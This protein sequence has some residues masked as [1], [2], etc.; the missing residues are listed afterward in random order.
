MGN[1][2]FAFRA[3]QDGGTVT[4]VKAGMEPVNATQEERQFTH[5]AETRLADPDHARTG[6]Y[7]ARLNAR[8]GRRQGPSIRLK[9]AAGDS[10]RADVY[11]RYDRES[12]AATLLQKGALVVGGTTI[13]VPGQAGSDQTQPLATRRHWLPF[14]GASL[15][16]VPQLLKVK[17]AELPTA[18]L[19][20]ELFNKDSQL[21]A[22]RTQA[23]R[24]TTSDEWQHLQAG[25]KADSAGFAH[26]SL[27][28]ESGTAA[29]FDDLALGIVA[30]TPYQ[31]NH[32]DPFGLNLV[33]IEQADVPNS[34]FQYNGKE[35][36]EDFN[37][38]WTDYGARM[39]DAQVGRW[40]SV[41]PL[42]DR[43]RRHSPYNYA[44]DNPIRFVDPD[45]MSP[46]PGITF[47]FAQGEAGAGMG[48]ALNYSRQE[49]IAYDKV[50]KTHFSM[51]S[52]SYLTNQN[53]Q[54]GSNNPQLVIGASAGLAVG[55]TQNWTHN[56]FG[57]YIEDASTHQWS[58]PTGAPSMKAEL[59]VGV[60]VS[61]DDFSLSFGPQIGAKA[62]RLSTV[63]EQSISLT[64][65]QAS[66]VSNATDIITESWDVSNPRAVLGRD[67][68]PTGFRATV[69]TLDTKGRKIDTGI[70]IFSTIAQ[71]K[72]GLTV[73]SNI[74]QSAEYM[75]ED[76]K[77]RK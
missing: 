28:N 6:D 26:V 44:F 56:T 63:V 46:W 29:Y 10:L 27:V 61:P 71:D 4:Q 37:L 50:G 58:S 70:S 17:Q 42:A 7:V 45:G 16:I 77:S 74:W 14:V 23:L 5:V 72:N 19:R 15:A 55:V 62:S 41:D 11:A 38:N 66:R 31:E 52:T 21:V 59:G 36:Q 35:K 76:Q 22:T 54:D 18:Y 12:G 73:P 51:T 1:L 39:Y 67:G 49:G 9:V 25:T 2:R 43:M 13:S 60:A 32:Y 48:Y 34:A 65:K 47:V 40:N 33:G 57:E 64:D 3:D 20:Y 30:A 24:R 75:N 53:L 8:T 68:T 69:G